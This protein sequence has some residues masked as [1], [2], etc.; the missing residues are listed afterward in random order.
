MVSVGMGTVSPGPTHTVPVW[1]P[2]HVS[3]SS[4]YRWQ[5]ILDEFRT[6]IKPPSP[7]H[8]RDHIIGLAA[9]TAVKDLLEKPWWAT[10]VGNK[11][12]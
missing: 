2:I 7:L 6:V 11:W 3:P 10:H 5:A 12:D 8:G 4:L 1:N 9:L